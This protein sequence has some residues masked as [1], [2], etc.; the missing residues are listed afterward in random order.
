MVLP[1]LG[2]GNFIIGIIRQNTVLRELTDLIKQNCKEK[3][4]QYPIQS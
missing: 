2:I 1:V 4:K 3:S